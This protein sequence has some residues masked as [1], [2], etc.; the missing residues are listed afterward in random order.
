MSLELSFFLVIFTGGGNPFGRSGSFENSR[1]EIK[2][3]LAK[4]RSN[5]LG[6]RKLSRECFICKHHTQPPCVVLGFIFIFKN[7]DIDLTFS[8]KS[9]ALMASFLHSWYNF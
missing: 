9:S 5:K 7:M 8:A 6:Q 4:A 2:F 1:L 3:G